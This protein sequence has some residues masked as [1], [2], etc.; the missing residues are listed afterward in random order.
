MACGSVPAMALQESSVEY[1]DWQTLAM[2]LALIAT[3]VPAAS[4]EKSSIEIVQ[5]GG[6]GW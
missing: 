6:T 4:I 1:S 2:A 5:N 3:A